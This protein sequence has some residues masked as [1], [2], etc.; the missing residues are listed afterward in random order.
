MTRLIVSH[1]VAFAAGIAAFMAGSYLW[2][3]R[4]LRLP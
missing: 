4:H 2:L 1:T 3:D